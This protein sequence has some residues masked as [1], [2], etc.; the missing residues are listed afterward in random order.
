MVCVV[1][2]AF[3]CINPVIPHLSVL[4]ELKH[5]ITYHPVHRVQLEFHQIITSGCDATLTWLSSHVGIQG[6]EIADIEARR[7]SSRPPEFIPIPLR[8]WFLEIRRT[9]ELW[10]RQW[11]RE[12]RDLCELKPTLKKWAKMFKM[13]RKEVVIN[14]LR[15]GDTLITPGYLFD[16]D[17]GFIRQPLCS[18]SEA[19]LLSIRHVLLDC[20]VLRNVR[21]YILKT[22]LMDRIITIHEKLD[23][24]KRSD[25]E[26]FKIFE[27]D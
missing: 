2:C 6:N 13:S 16:Y 1:R 17:D 10:S 26:R 4:Q 8:Y 5:V 25:K 9:K 18:W 12:S 23:W 7:A 20:P 27:G 15:L 21:K 14:R 19:E 11:R 24:R 3:K 22:A